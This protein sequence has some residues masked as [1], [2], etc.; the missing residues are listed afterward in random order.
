M[1]E[2]NP[3]LLL[4][5][6]RN[7]YY[8]HPGDTEAIDIFLHHLKYHQQAERLQV[9]DVGCGRGGTAQYIKSQLGNISS[10]VGF[11]YDERAINDANLC[12]NDI[13][14]VICDIKNID[15]FSDQ[16]FNLIYL[17]S[18]FYALPEATQR[19]CLK[20]LASLAQEG[21]ILVIFDYVRLEEDITELYDF[22]GKLMRPPLLKDVRIWLDEAGWEIIEEVDLTTK[23]QEWYTQFL[24][25]MELKKA[26]LDQK[27]T[28][29]AINQVNSLFQS[30]LTK[31]KNE[32]WSGNI[33][34][35]RAARHLFFSG[36]TI[37][38]YH[39]DSPSCEFK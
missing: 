3:R 32:Q 18:V 29:D 36:E 37:D 39:N 33:L 35:S 1:K 7:G 14:F 20:K 34:Y 15:Q 26:D 9:L 31:I 16:K 6:L 27:F 38:N 25:Q 13:P 2:N 30:I 11:D 28:E 23:Y 17:F 24:Q 5:Y 22:S 19:D 8:A 10:I 21:A 4:G 12:Y